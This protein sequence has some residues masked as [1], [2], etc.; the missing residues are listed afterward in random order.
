M[1]TAFRG[2]IAMRHVCSLTG[3]LLLALPLASIA[4]EFGDHCA[5]GLA[6]YSAMVETDCSISWKHPE[7][8]KT[9]CFSSEK[10]K[11]QF[12]KDPAAN[13]RKAQDAF[14]KLKDD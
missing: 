14:E 4:G 9:Y 12:M 5:N 10:S 8:G 6:N 7:S 2:F 1:F 13:L 11:A 3:V